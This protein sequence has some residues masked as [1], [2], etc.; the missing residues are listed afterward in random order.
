MPFLIEGPAG[1]PTMVV[2]NCTPAQRRLGIRFR[3][4]TNDLAH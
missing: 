4:F 2:L 3:S 1:T